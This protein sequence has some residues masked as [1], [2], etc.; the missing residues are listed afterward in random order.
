I[1]QVALVSDTAPYRTLDSL[2]KDLED[3]WSALP[4]VRD[5]ERWGVPEPE[6]DVEMDLG[7]LEELHLPVGQVM[8]AMSGESADMPGGSVETDRRSFSVRSSGSYTSLDEIR[9]TVLRG[10]GGRIVRVGDVARVS[11]GYADSTYRARFNGHRAVFV[12]ATQQAGTTVQTIRDRLYAELNPFERR[13]PRGVTLKRGF[14]QAHNVSHR[15]AR[16]GEDFL[17]ALGLVLLTLLPLGPR[18]A[19]TVMISIPLSLA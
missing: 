2:A 7:R 9:A 3:D 19:L 10:G 13:L 16:L 5:A 11:W 14:D 15:L 6:V 17:I 1:V 8:A 18:A 12:T 4:G